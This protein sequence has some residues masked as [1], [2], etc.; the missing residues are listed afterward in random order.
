MA[1]AR[2][3]PTLVAAA[4]FV[5]SVTFF[6]FDKVTELGVAAGV[7]YVVVVYLASLS[8]RR[9]WIWGTAVFAC[10]LTLVGYATSPEGGEDWKVIANRIIAILAVLLVAYICDIADRFRR[11]FEAC[12]Q[13]LEDRVATLAA[14][15]QVS[16]EAAPAGIVMIDQQGKILLVNAATERM[17][18]YSRDDLVGQSIELLVP[19]AHRGR[20]PQDRQ[21]FFAAKQSRQMG[22]G[23]DLYGRRRDGT[24]IPVEIGL[25]VVDSTD[26]VVVLGTIVDITER[27]MLEADQARMAEALK[28]QAESLAVLNSQLAE[29]NEELEQFAYVA[30]HDLQTPLRQVTSF[31]EFLEQEYKGKL[32][33]TA[34]EYI[35]WIVDGSK[36]MQALINDL[37]E[38]SR[39]ES[40]GSP[41]GPIS[42][43]Q[44]VDDT[45]LLLRLEIEESGGSVTR[46]DLPAIR[47]DKSQVSRL[48]QNLIGNGL[49][50]RGD[51]APKVHIFADESDAG[52]TV[53][54]QDNG[55][56]IEPSYHERIFEVFRRLHTQ[57]EYPGTG[58]GLAVCKRIANRHGGK[59]WLESEVGKGSTFSFMIPNDQGD[60]QIERSGTS[61]VET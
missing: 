22:T 35:N 8:Q 36:R 54:V 28:Q 27:K 7:S 52:V 4:V 50:Y 34:D 14:R 1:H 61:G 5:T 46:D 55:I 6:L 26:G 23:K 16:V 18:D 31:A 10:V 42:M 12:E 21:A 47:G 41:F 40:R 17:F 11:K 3:N 20:H 29:S 51:E 15:F 13:A 44:I 2:C 9:S 45:L 25:N 30:S 49:K 39:I 56:G 53:S 48:M 57:Q 60:H 37:L 24:G 32:D 59:I 33:E 19:D 43:N 38:Y 58:I